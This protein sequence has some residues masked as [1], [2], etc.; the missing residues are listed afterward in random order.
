VADPPRIVIAEGH[1]SDPT[2]MAASGLR[3]LADR[4]EALGGS[5]P[6]VSGPIPEDGR[7]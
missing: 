1:Y 4:V 6:V 5:L 2:H 3:G 7:G